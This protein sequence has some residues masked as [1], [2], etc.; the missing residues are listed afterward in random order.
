MDSINASHKQP[1]CGPYIQISRRSSIGTVIQQHNN[2]YSIQM[3]L[4]EMESLICEHA[5]GNVAGK[6]STV[7]WCKY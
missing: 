3:V 6:V 5:S 1:V 2:T 7:Y 4:R